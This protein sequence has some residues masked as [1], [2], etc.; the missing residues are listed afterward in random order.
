MKTGI[1]VLF[2]VF[3]FSLMASTSYGQKSES[4]AQNITSIVNT[5]RFILFGGTY[6]LAG[7]Q[8]LNGLQPAESAVF[9][10]DTYTGKTWVLKVEKS[11]NGRVAVWIPVDEPVSVS[12]DNKGEQKRDNGQKNPSKA[13]KTL[14]E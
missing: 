9:K 4:G 1:R 12:A 7:E 13:L 6:A 2:A 5:A 8:K 14:D 11:V 10:L 3:L